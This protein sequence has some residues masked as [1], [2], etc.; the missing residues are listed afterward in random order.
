MRGAEEFLF[1]VGSFLL[2]DCLI[3]KWTTICLFG[4]WWIYLGLL[5]ALLGDDPKAIFVF[6]L[7]IDFG[8]EFF[9]AWWFAW[10]GYA[11]GCNSGMSRSCGSNSTRICTLQQAFHHVSMV[12]HIS[13]SLQIPLFFFLCLYYKSIIT[14]FDPFAVQWIIKKIY[15]NLPYGCLRTDWYL[16]KS[17]LLHIIVWIGV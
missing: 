12:Q 4:K 11:R 17:L 5:E 6:E 9:L 7:D 16:L 1:G 10:G 8:L 15:T 3:S 14:I 13:W 2:G